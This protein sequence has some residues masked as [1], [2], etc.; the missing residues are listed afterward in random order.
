VSPTG[1]DVIIVS[2]NTRQD[3]LATLDSLLASPPRDLRQVV[4]VDNASSDGSVD[5]VRSKYPSVDVVPLDRN[6]GF[7]AANNIGVRRTAAPLV[8]LLNSD[9]LVAPGAIERLV[10]RLVAT[11]AAVAGPRLVDGAGWPEV[12]HGPML[13][14]LAELRQRSRVRQASE[15][16]PEARRFVESLLATERDVDWVSGACL[17]VR[18]QAAVE[19][20]LLD[21][22]YFM[23][24]EDVD[25]CA[26]IRARGG[27]VIFTPAAEITHLRGRSIRASGA[28]SVHYDRSHI[29]FYEKHH[30]QWAPLLKLWIRV[31]G[32]AIR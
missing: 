17:L 27:R 31:R 24:E 14:P 26:A 7:A 12:S 13:S 8:L 15:R 18:R 3:L 10:D 22:R 20:G 29:A 5:A 16:T 32:R 19:A 28:G 4:V 11:G 23:Y 9:T 30:P 21:E 6:A 25:F 2:F 1:L